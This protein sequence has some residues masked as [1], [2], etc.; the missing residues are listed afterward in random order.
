MTNQPVSAV[1]LQ[2]RKHRRRIQFDKRQLL[3]FPWQ[4]P[5]ARK[6]RQILIPLGVVEPGRR[7][8]EF[9]D[10]ETGLQKSH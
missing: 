2:I 4:K 5:P 3:S 6:S 8:T 1:A 10:V 7:G 9:L